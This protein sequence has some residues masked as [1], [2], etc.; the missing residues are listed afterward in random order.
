MSTTTESESRP[1]AAPVPPNG[2][3]SELVSG[4]ID[5]GQKLIKQQVDML[6]AEIRE[7]FRK[8]KDVAIYLGIGAGLA[9]VGG[10]MLLVALVHLVRY[11]TDWDLA[12]CWGLVGGLAV[13]FG[14]V[15]FVIGGRILKSYNPLPDKTL[16]ALQEN[17][18]W[19][20]KAQPQT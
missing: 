12:G 8:T 17:V 15:A 9:S 11:L 18:S 10:V 20:A 4:I 1:A 19:I 2:T 7:D 6:R 5:D 3:M 16:N 13:A 14:A